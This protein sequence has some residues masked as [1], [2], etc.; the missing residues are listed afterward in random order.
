M[1][2]LLHLITADELA[3]LRK[4]SILAVQCSVHHV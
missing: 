3:D 2:Q 4:P 1:K